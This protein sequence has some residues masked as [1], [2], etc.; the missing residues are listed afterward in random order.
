MRF[1]PWIVAGLL[2]VAV[3]AASAES[4][5]TGPQVFTQEDPE[6]F[7]AFC[8]DLDRCLFSDEPA[9]CR[10]WEWY[11]DDPKVSVNPLLGLIVLDPDGCLR[12]KVEDHQEYVWYLLEYHLGDHLEHGPGE[13][14][15]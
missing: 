8:L 5:G 12:Q 7:I 3:P 14:P 10:L 11:D 1:I 13:G 2:L 4:E 15:A 6:R 9:P